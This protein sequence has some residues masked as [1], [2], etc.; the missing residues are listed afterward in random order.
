M[1]PLTKTTY[2]I[3]AE[4]V[5]KIIDLMYQVNFDYTEYSYYITGEAEE[6]INE[7]NN[8]LDTAK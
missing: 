7:V 1:K 6:L 3:S 5:D 2:E 4:E 8:I